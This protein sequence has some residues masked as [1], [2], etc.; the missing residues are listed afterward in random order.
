V[1]AG[2]AFGT[3]PAAATRIDIMSVLKDAKGS[4]TGVRSGRLKRS[5]VVVQVA[6]AVVLL[7][8]AGLL[9]VS[10]ERLQR[11]DPGYRAEAVLSAELFGNF[12]KYPDS[13]SLL[14]FYLP[15]LDRLTTQGGVVSAAITNA[16]PLSTIAPGSTPF[17]IEGSVTDN[18][19]RRPT[20]DVRIVSPQYFATLGIPLISGRS[21]E[22]SDHQ[23]APR[24]T[25][26]N[27]SMVR[28]WEGREP[29]GSHISFDGGKSWLT[30][31]GVAGDV[32]LFGLDQN[33]VAQAYTPLR[34]M[35][36]GVAGRIL[37]RT[38]G[39]PLA[40]KNTLRDAV[41]AFDSEM[42]I[43]NVHTLEDL[44]D[45]TLSKPRLTAMLL[46]VFA[47]LA[48]TVTIAGITGVVA[49]SVSQRKQEFGIRMAMGAQRGQVLRMVLR[50]GLLLI[51]AG[52]ATG[53][54]GA[55]AAGRLL[56]GMLYNTQTSDPVALVAVTVTLIGCGIVACII[57]AWRAITADPIAALRSN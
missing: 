42:P 13:K 26:I 53:L 10:F 20:A 3:L 8:A 55:L 2:V 16:V 44:R 48:L 28:F 14:N 46:A 11:V 57:P 27:R 43:E 22:E 7:A 30:V 36:N 52:L 37:I 35:Q 50:E 51:V 29:L 24:V 6:M 25:I 4:S 1:L 18:P 32:R 33:P 21:F 49:T 47:G 31:V 34:Q 12:T 15:V 23:T 56:A 38:T 39:D 54:A 40:V 19:D 9:L 17:Q 45:T 41:R 5:L